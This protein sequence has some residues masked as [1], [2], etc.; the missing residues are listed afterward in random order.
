[1]PVMDGMELY[2]ELERRFPE[3]GKRI[4]FVT[5]DVLD[6]DKQRFLESSGAPFVSKPFD[7]AEVRRLVRRLLVA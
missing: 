5:G 6:A 1:M 4:I 2:R 3:L 7:P